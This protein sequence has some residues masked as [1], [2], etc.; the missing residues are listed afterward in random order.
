[1]AHN[2]RK[3]KSNILYAG[4][5]WCIALAAQTGKCLLCNFIWHTEW[6]CWCHK[7]LLLHWVFQKLCSQHFILRWRSH[8]C[9]IRYWLKAVGLLFYKTFPRQSYNTCSYYGMKKRSDHCFISVVR[10]S[11]NLLHTPFSLALGCRL[12]HLLPKAKFQCVFIRC[13]HVGC[14]RE[15]ELTLIS[16]ACLIGKTA[17]VSHWC[18]HFGLYCLCRLA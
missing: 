16:H 9:F 15:L 13:S 18:T 2:P 14:A 7:C 8:R 6:Q 1:M 5:L 3:K 17:H 10:A 12:H 11:C 4:G